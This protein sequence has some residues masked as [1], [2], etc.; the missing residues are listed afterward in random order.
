MSKRGAFFLESSLMI[1][2][3]LIFF[4]IWWIFFL[5]FKEIAGWQLKELILL[6]AIGTGSYGL[7][8]ILFAGTKDLSKMIMGGDL[9]PFLTQPKNV[10]LHIMGSKSRAKGWGDLITAVLLLIFGGLLNLLT[11]FLAV[12][13]MIS[14][15]L[16][17]TSI[18]IIA[19]SL[20]FWLGSI[21]SVSKKYCD[22]LLL[23]SVYPPNI[24]SGFLKIVMFTL[25]PAG[26]I[27]YIP[28][29]LI[30]DF[31]WDKLAA[32]LFSAAFFFGLS[33]TVFYAG[34][35]HYESGNRFG[36]R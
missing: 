23:F 36:V 21:E 16:V 27:T 2:N 14:G 5:Q 33:F 13:S 34:L 35:K 18:N 1:A 31:T 22:A 15:C 6:M 25:I 26:V 30:R 19:H 8:Q 24:Y 4:S 28:V 11:V 29:E 20:S 12:I 3:N 17:F 7:M 32:L 9:D 10:L